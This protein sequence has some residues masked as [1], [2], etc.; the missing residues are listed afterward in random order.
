MSLEKKN[1]LRHL[2]TVLITDLR[3]FYDELAFKR[4]PVFNNLVKKICK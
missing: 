4:I 2:E 1:S 3:Q